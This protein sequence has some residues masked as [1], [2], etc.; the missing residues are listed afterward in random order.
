[1]VESVRPL[2]VDERK[3]HF[4]GGMRFVLFHIL[5]L[6]VCRCYSKRKGFLGHILVSH[7]SLLFR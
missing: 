3:S 1:M 7:S 2:F 6:C 5:F 4:Y